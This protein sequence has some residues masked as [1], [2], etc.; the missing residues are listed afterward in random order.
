MRRF[1]HEGSDRVVLQVTCNY[2]IPLATNVS[3]AAKPRKCLK[4]IQP[5]KLMTR[6]RFPSP[7]QPLSRN[8]LPKNRQREGR[9]K[10][11]TGRK[12]ADRG[13]PMAK[14][15]LDKW[16][17]AACDDGWEPPAVSEFDDDTAGPPLS[18]QDLQ[19]AREDL[20]RWRTTDKFRRAVDLPHKRCRAHEFKDPGRQFLLDAWTL[21]E[22][23]RHKPVDEVRLAG[24][25]EQWPDGYVR[26]G[27]VVEN[28]EATIALMKGRKMW[29]EYQPGA[30]SELDGVE[31]WEGRADAIPGALEKAIKDKIAKRYGS[32]LWLVVYLNLNDYG[33]RQSETGQAIASIKQRH[34]DAFTQL[35]V[36]WKG[37]LL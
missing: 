16:I 36:I 37:K 20:A 34:A 10:I 23:V 6:V 28:V 22:F 31:N 11:A 13:H 15:A 12:I 19:S 33:I 21:A 29:E 14:D 24:R 9:G 32:K 4:N 7:V 8:F 27:D 30:K 3:F 1:E 35:F 25:S 18:I 26:I 17:D 5:S 2:L